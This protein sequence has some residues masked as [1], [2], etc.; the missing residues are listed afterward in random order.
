MISELELPAKVE[1]VNEANRSA[2][3]LQR[4]LLAFFSPLVGQKVQKH[5][6]SL[7]AKVDKALKE[8]LSKQPSLP[9]FHVYR[10]NSVYTLRW[11]V[12]SSKSYGAGCSY[13]EATAYVG[14]LVGDVLVSL[15]EPVVL[16]D[17]YTVEGVR[18]ACQ[19]VRELK[20]AYEKARDD[21]YPFDV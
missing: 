16:R 5:D 7:L 19:K 14:D 10:S 9:V 20:S 18:A 11:T 17:D 6:G 21:C 4:Q 1:A 3:E 2:M 8:Y 13:A 12:K 15:G